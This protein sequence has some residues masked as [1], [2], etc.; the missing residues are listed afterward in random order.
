MST[1]LR[2]KDNDEDAA[3]AVEALGD[4]LHTALSAQQIYTLEE[5][6]ERLRD[7]NDDA[8][9]KPIATYVGASVRMIPY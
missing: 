4:A 2:F 6:I 5:V 3:I 1:V 8:R 9:E 7:L